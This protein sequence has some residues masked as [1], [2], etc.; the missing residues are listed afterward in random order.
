MSKCELI[1]GY[2]IDLPQIGQFTK[3]DPHGLGADSCVTLEAA[4]L[5]FKLIIDRRMKVSLIDHD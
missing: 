1:S 5:L 3:R 4:L 2:A